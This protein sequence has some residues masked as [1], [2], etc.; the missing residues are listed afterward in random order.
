[1]RETSKTTVVISSKTEQDNYIFQKKLEPLREEF[2]DTEFACIHP[3]GLQSV[4]E[5]SVGVVILNSAEWSDKEAQYL[6]DLKAL[7]YQGP[8]LIASKFTSLQ[9]KSV[10]MADPRAVLLEKPFDIKDLRGI[11]R[12]MLLARAVAQRVHRRFVTSQDAQVE[13][14]G[15]NESYLSRVRN[16]SRGGAYLEFVQ[17]VPLRTGEMVRL[18]MA[19]QDV[20]RTYL[21]P[22]KVVWT[23][24][25]GNDKS[26]GVEFV[27]G[28]DVQKL[29]LGA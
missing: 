22:A 5:P 27:G 29:I 13:P 24:K 17:A 4:I 9:L 25:D 7:E 16:L 2:E 28:G 21:M 6:G 1:M 12:K 26:V 3:V 19:L 15:R 23:G 8:I 18:K 20:N 10:P 14:F 11:V